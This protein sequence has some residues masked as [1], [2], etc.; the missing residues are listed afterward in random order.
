MVLRDSL[1]FLLGRT[2]DFV[3]GRLSPVRAGRAVAV[4]LILWW[5]VGLEAAGFTAIIKSPETAERFGAVHWY[6]KEASPQSEDAP[7]C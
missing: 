6:Q 7:A 4:A 1:L 2:G 3:R 5:A